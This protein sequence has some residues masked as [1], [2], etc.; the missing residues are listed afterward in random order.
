MQRLLAGRA[1]CPMPIHAWFQAQF[2]HA[3]PLRRMT[4]Y[5]LSTVG[6]T[7]VRRGEGRGDERGAWGWA[8]LDAEAEASVVDGQNRQG[9][10]AGTDIPACSHGTIGGR[11]KSVSPGCFVGG[12]VG[13]HKGSPA[14][15]PASWTCMVE[16]V[17]EGRGRLATTLQQSASRRGCSCR[18]REDGYSTMHSCMLG[19]KLY[20]RCMLERRLCTTRRE[21]M[22]RRERDGIAS[23]ILE[24]TWHRA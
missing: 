2:R 9:V 10:T 1:P 21:E 19:A 16:C 6:V 23:A 20:C 5:E 12:P 14:C 13:L 3:S 4:I 17:R 15:Q 8:H 24:S 22:G 11:T 18:C 7:G